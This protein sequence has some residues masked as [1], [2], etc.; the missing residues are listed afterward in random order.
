MHEAGGRR[1]T[2]YFGLCGMSWSDHVLGGAGALYQGLV[3]EYHG[4]LEWHPGVAIG[5]D[6]TIGSTLLYLAANGDDGDTTGR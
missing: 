6:D 1:A 5:V 4:I 2:L 3:R